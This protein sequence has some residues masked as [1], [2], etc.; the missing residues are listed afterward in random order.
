M[1]RR[2]CTKMERKREKVYP[3]LGIFSGLLWKKEE[4][5]LLLEDLGG[6]ECGS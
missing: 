3:K 2:V 4:F 6:Y 1:A 5:E